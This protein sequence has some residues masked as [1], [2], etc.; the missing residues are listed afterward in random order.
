MKL[1]KTP[2]CRVPWNTWRKLKTLRSRASCWVLT[3]TD[4]E[5]KKHPN[6]QEIEFEIVLQKTT[7][8]WGKQEHYSSGLSRGWGVRTVT[9]MMPARIVHRSKGIVLHHIGIFI[10]TVYKIITWPVERKRR[11]LSIT[12]W[13]TYTRVQHTCWQYVSASSKRCWTLNNDG[14]TPRACHPFQHPFL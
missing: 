5:K 1:S 13:T 12:R 8:F 9:K 3:T 4:P 7:N 2:W 6:C 14:I 10:M 11:N